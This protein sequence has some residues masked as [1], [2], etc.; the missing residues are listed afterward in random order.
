MISSTVASA[1][2]MHFNAYSFMFSH[3]FIMCSHRCSMQRSNFTTQC[4]LN[5]WENVASCMWYFPLFLCHSN[6]IHSDSIAFILLF[7]SMRGM[8]IWI[9]FSSKLKFNVHRQHRLKFL[10]DAWPLHSPFLLTI[11]VHWICLWWQ[12]CHIFCLVFG[13]FKQNPHLNHP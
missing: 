5:R 1:S 12:D 2:S 7:A 9:L 6:K 8:G 10:C 11:F 13:D 3:E 4:K